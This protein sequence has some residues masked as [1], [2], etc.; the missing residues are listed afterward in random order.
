MSF[1]DAVQHE[2]FDKFDEWQDTTAT[3]LSYLSVQRRLGELGARLINLNR[4]AFLPNVRH[5]AVSVP[6]EH[7][8]T[9]HVGVLP[10]LESDSDLWPHETLLEP[11]PARR[12]RMRE[13]LW[14]AGLHTTG[15]P[16]S[17]Y[18]QQ[19]LAQVPAE[20]LTALVNP[21]RAVSG[22]A[23]N[24]YD[25]ETSLLV[26]SRPL[27]V[28]RWQ[29]LPA[30]PTLRGSVGAHELV[31]A[32]DVEEFTGEP[33]MFYSAYTELRG[34]HVGALIAEAAI[35]NGRL[36]RREY[37]EH[38]STTIEVEEIRQMHDIDSGVL[39]NSGDFNQLDDNMA[40]LHLGMLGYLGS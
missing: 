8:N 24:H 22:G 35:A 28:A 2:R 34:Y 18:T 38:D 37:E 30:H 14:Q 39:L 26:T 31:H 40:V 32:H 10:Y 23:V 6:R 27:V 33:D 7:R 3:V 20:E 25:E 16:L 17:E 9:D 1:Y 5:S 11:T 12:G 15:R 36:G 19:A 4:D 21:R 13:A 29:S